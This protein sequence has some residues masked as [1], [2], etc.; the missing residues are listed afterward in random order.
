M[1]STLCTIFFFFFISIILPLGAEKNQDGRAEKQE[2][3]TE[4][5]QYLG[6]Y[7]TRTLSLSFSTSI[8]H[9]Y[10]Y[11]NLHIRMCVREGERERLLTLF[12]VLSLFS[13]RW[14]SYIYK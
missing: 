12:T 4:N 7:N 1:N 13:H 2:M 9:S 8:L 14:T 11:L 10:L 5:S 3:T 6:N